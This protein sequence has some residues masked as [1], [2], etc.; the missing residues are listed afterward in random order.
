MLNEVKHLGCEGEVSIAPE[1]THAGRVLHSAP[2]QDD[3][4]RM[5]QETRDWQ[6]SFYP[7]LRRRLSTG[8][9][10]KAL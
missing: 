9:I 3:K 2:L 4:R 6:I 8:R 7:I 1:G 10:H 5:T